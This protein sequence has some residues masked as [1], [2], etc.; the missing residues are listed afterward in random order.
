MKREPPSLLPD[1]FICPHLLFDAP[2]SKKAWD[3]LLNEL[4]ALQV[5]LSYDLPMNFVRDMLSVVVV[6]TFDSI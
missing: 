6:A 1:Y 3:R 5:A 4:P 2:L